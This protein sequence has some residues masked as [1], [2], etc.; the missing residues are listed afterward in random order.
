MFVFPFQTMWHHSWEII[1]SCAKVLTQS[2]IRLLN[3]C[4]SVILPGR[5]FLRRLIDLTRGVR[6]AHY[7]IRFTKACRQDLLV[8]LTFLQNYNGKTFFLQERWEVSSP[9]DLYTD[10]AGS[11]GYGAILGRH[12]FCGEWPV[13]WKSFNITF[14]ELF[15]IAIALHVWGN[16]MSNRCISFFTDNSALVDILNKQTSKHP[17]VMALVRDVVLTA[18]RHNIVFERITFRGLITPEPT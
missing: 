12:W 8:W 10:A 11:K 15:P 6:R 1:L 16:R 4:C 3:F 17:L 9:L 7:H 14:L 13:S 2:L 18:L 5:A